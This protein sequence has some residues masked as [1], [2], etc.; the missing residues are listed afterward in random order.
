MNK[1]LESLGGLL[2]LAGAAGL[3]HK[4][5]GW[6]LFGVVVRVT[7]ATPFL[8]DHEIA[9]YVAMIVLGIAVLVAADAAGSRTA[10]SPAAGSHA[11]DE[12]SD[13]S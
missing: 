5:V 1:P 4:I 13:E 3:V 12:P 11:G 6:A 10:G 9:T 8:R 2:V 7:R